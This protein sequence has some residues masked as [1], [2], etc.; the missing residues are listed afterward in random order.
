MQR[1][2]TSIDNKR[3]RFQAIDV[4]RAIIDEPSDDDDGDEGSETEDEV[5]QDI[6]SADED[7]VSDAATDLSLANGASPSTQ[8]IGETEGQAEDSDT[9]P[10]G[11]A[12]DS[13]TE[14]KGQ[15]EDSDTEPKGQ[16][17][18][19]DT[20]T[21]GQAEDS[22]TEPEGQAED[23]DT[24]PEGQAEDSDT[25][26]E[27]QAEDSDTEPEGQA[28][29]SNT[30]PEGQA[31]DSDT[32][33]KG[34]AEDSDS[35]PKGQAEDSD[36]EPKGQAEDSDTEPKGQAE[37]SDTETEGQA[38]DSDTEPEGQA[39]DS[40][41]ETEAVNAIDLLQVLK[42]PVNLAGKNKYKWSGSVPLR[43]RAY[44]SETRYANDR[45]PDSDDDD[46]DA[47]EEVRPSFTRNVDIVELKALLGLYYLAGVPNMNGVTTYELFD[48]DCGVAYFRA[49]MPQKRFTFLT[50]CIPLMTKVQGKKKENV[51]D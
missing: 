32:E 48:K 17:E 9:E 33:P 5:I 18:D 22:D 50:N 19:S 42:V 6:C 40:D 15:A 23:S 37:D 31:E 30:E 3:R 49:I 46:D 8:N 7:T 13:D 45:Q 21:E 10:E 26:P 38:E 27:G 4:L 24:E 20:E 39:E 1:R 28:E 47:E 16:A 25:E 2:S 44:H 11:Q 51:I 14:P 34:Q 43:T 29:D 35:E 36:S 41:T 12:E